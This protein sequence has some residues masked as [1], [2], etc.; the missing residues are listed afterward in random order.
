MSY[1]LRHLRL[2]ET[3]Y[4]FIRDINEL[5]TGRVNNSWF[6]F[7]QQYVMLILWEN[8]QKNIKFDKSFCQEWTF[9]KGLLLVS[10]LSGFQCRKTKW[11]YM[12]L[13]ICF[14][15][16]LDFRNRCVILKYV[17]K[18]EGGLGSCNLEVLKNSLFR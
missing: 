10:F 3:Y 18:R 5:N 16:K 1:I 4:I 2:S 15:A 11:A 6:F 14:F 17:E 9:S 13:C 7:I 12:L 8:A